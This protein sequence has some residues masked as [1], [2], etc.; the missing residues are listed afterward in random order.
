M[1]GI[2]ADLPTSRPGGVGFSVTISSI[3]RIMGI[4]NGTT[5]W[6][7]WERGAVGTNRSQGTLVDAFSVF[8]LDGARRG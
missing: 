7:T 5:T 8:Q 3:S 2:M 6:L 4:P 1:V